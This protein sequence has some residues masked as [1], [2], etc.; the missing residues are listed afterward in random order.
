MFGQEVSDLY[1]FKRTHSYE[2]VW[3]LKG[4]ASNTT[5]Y[6]KTRKLY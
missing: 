5:P 4:G 3:F 2:N 1:K 6:L